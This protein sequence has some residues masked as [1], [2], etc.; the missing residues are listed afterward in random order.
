M[1][2]QLCV[3]LLE[4]HGVKP[5]S[6]RL[7]VAEALETAQ[8]PLSLM[9]LETRIKT[10]DKSGIFR[11]LTLFREHHMVHVIEDGGD[12]VRYELCRSHDDEHDDD[13]HVHFFC[14]V[15]RQ[16]YC[17]DNIKIPPVE[18]P[19]GF[20]MNTVNY[21]VKGTCPNCRDRRG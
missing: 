19:G 2:E 16:T 13:M 21:M 5:T 4:H 12:G 3:K 10:I 20:V 18:L 6:N 9:E 1:N 17:L 15:C 11:A 7:L 14:E 8:R